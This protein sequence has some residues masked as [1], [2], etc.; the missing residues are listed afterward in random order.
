[1][2]LK[3]RD[4]NGVETPVAG[5]NGTSGELIPSV[6]YY[7]TGFLNF[8]N[9]TDDFADVTILNIENQS[10]QYRVVFSTPMPDTDYV[11]VV[12]VHNTN[13][14]V[15]VATAN[16]TAN[17]FIVTVRNLVA[18]MRADR[19]ETTD[20]FTFVLDD[21]YFSWSA[22]KLMTDE[23]RALD[24]A[25][26]ADLSDRVET[27]ETLASDVIP[28]EAS[29]N[30][31]LATENDIPDISGKQ[32]KI[33]VSYNASTLSDSTIITGVSAVGENP[34]DIK[35]HPLNKF[36]TYISGKLTGAVSTI[37][38]RNLTPNRVLIA[39]SSGKVGVSSITTTLLECLSGL[40]GNIQTQLTALGVGIL[41]H[42]TSETDTGM[43]WTYSQNIYRRVIAVSSLANGTLATITA[44]L[45]IICIR[46]TVYYNGYYYNI[47]APTSSAA[48][49]FFVDIRYEKSTGK[50]DC[51][52]QGPFSGSPANIIIEYYK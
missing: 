2:S 10:V 4:A 8:S 39:D 32:D 5:L 14:Q 20:G 46:G 44:N 48:S 9:L 29:A 49:T 42:S 12:D 1:M 6:S 15:E 19:G 30:N 33:T 40:T 16:K 35:G 22:F 50:V 28:S 23:S 45:N 47:D 26:I 34:T 27:L 43:T 52:I 38:D 21:N 41:K 37:Q 17:G 11:V 36:W 24:E 3:F 31:Q 13:L 7:Q 25:E 18:T 51:N